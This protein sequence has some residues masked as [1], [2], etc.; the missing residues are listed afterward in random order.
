MKVNVTVCQLHSAENGLENDWNA[1]IDHVRTHE[2]DFLLLPEMIFS[3]WLAA[4]QQ[5]DQAQ[6]QAAVAMNEQWLAQLDLFG[7]TVV[8][9]SRPTVRDGRNQN[10]AYAWSAD[11]LETVHTKYFLPNEP[12]FW[13]ATWYE[14]AKSADFTAFKRAGVTF[15]AMIC[16][17]LWFT[18][19]AR[20]YARQ[21]AQ[22]IVNPRATELT[23]DKWLVGGRAAAVMAGAYCLSSNHA[24]DCGDFEMGGVGWIIDPN[25]V[26]LGVTSAETPFVTVTIDLAIADAAKAT[27]PRDVLE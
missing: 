22:I 23:T 1:L 7:E 3:R 8:L 17:D 4:S 20:A 2:S 16:T 19:H 21:G 24:G 27:Y 14:R 15:G 12:Y 18:E 6:W 13:E 11:G 5:V 26:V 10:E 25:G 9:G